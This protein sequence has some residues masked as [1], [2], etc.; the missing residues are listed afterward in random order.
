M[1]LFNEF[2]NKSVT[3]KQIKSGN[4]MNERQK[5]TLIG[6][7]LRGI[8][9]KSEVVFNQSVQGM[10]KKVHHVVKISLNQ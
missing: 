1:N 3:I 9:S 7:G 10:F 8:G 4:K 5:G 6:L 2:N